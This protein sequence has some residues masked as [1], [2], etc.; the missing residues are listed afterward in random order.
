M[1]TIKNINKT[2]QQPDELLL[3]SY[4]KS[5]EM[6]LLG[7]LYNRYTHLVYG[8]C[9]KYFKDRFKSQDGVID[10]FENVVKDIERFEIKNF[11]SWLYV[12]AKNH[13]LMELRKEKSERNKNE[14]F[15]ATEFMESTTQL[16]PIDEVDNENLEKQLKDCIEKLKIEQRK[17][18]KL[19]YFE[20]KCYKEIAQKLKTDELKV[21]SGI[22]NGKRNLKICLENHKVTKL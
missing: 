11:K 17:C 20:N 15:L 16:H 6:D 5:G 8:I 7:V 13:C 18:I 19:F 10:V 1:S 12:V 14:H 22:Q 4:L 9:L 3:E 21:K 2:D